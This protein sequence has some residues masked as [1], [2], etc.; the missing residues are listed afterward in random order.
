MPEG[1]GCDTRNE[2]RNWPNVVFGSGPKSR[3]RLTIDAT[4]SSRRRCVG[5]APPA[6]G[7]SARSSIASNTSLNVTPQAARCARERQ[8]PAG[9]GGSTQSRCAHPSRGIPGPQDRRQLAAKRQ[10]PREAAHREPGLAP[11]Q[12]PVGRRIAIQRTAGRLGRFA[13]IARARCRSSSTAIE[14]P[15]ARSDRTRARDG[16]T[17][18][19][20]P[21]RTGRRACPRARTACSARARSRV[22]GPLSGRRRRRERRATVCAG[23]PVYSKRARRGVEGEAGE[24]E[25]LERSRR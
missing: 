8:A 18:R 14:S 12:A 21:R 16:T 15:P 9:R 10:E 3:R 19:R 2:L 23:P 11:E 5:C 6:S 24:A 22:R 7:S 17:R 25:R 1:I 13:A 4:A 20:R